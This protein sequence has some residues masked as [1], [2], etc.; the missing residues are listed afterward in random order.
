MR[1]FGSERLDKV[2]STLGM[3]DGEAIV[4][5]WVNKSLE[6][7]QAKVEGRNFDIRK[8]LLKFDDVMNDQRKAIFGQRLDILE[9]D[10]LAD[11]VQDMRHDIID[12]L[13]NTYMPPKSYAD[14]WDTEGLYASL[15][16]QL[17]IDVPVVKWAD[18]EGV[19]DETIREKLEK[20]A[21]EMMAEK[22]VAFGP[23]TMRQV[24]K[25]ILLQ[26]IDRKW[27][28]H[29]ITLEH[30][31]SV[32]GFRGYAQRDPLNE[33]KSEAFQ[34]F[35]ALLD[36]LRVDV[37]KQLSQVRPISEEEQ[38]AMMQQMIAQQEQL[39]QAAQ[40]AQAAGDTKVKAG[41]VAFDEN[42]RSTWGNPGRNDPCP[43]GSGK[44]FKHCHG[45]L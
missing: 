2:L 44:K 22:A 40:K 42:D 38:R 31:R 15:L 32:V 25:Q 24:E 3:K 29:L 20:A 11:V 41:T 26:T 34:L 19:D 14:Q 43:C 13:V 8:Q 17:N 27:R 10:D 12:D 37:T 28:E 21:D 35:E 5:P 45:R 16:E 30:L 36:G 6:R 7:A 33:Y 18:E 1:I 23:D 9:A 4:H 39:K